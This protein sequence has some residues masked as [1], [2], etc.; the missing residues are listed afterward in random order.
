[1]LAPEDAIKQFLMPE[2]RVLLL[3]LD[4]TTII[5]QLRKSFQTCHWQMSSPEQLL[6][7]KKILSVMDAV[8]VY[9]IS[10]IITWR[11]F[12]ALLRKIQQLL[13]PSGYW[14][15]IDPMKYHSKH[16]SKANEE[17]DQQLK[18]RNYKYGVRDFYTVNAVARMNQLIFLHDYEFDQDK[19]LLI[20]QFQR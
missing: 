9:G 20:W 14:I 1:M 19:R 13:K 15:L 16:I 11:S 12:T 8:V 5:E 17:V 4:E 18:K 6:Q 2:D 10:H 3:T 7:S